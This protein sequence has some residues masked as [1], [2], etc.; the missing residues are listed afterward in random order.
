VV[1]ASGNLCGLRRVIP[2]RVKFTSELYNRAGSQRLRPHSLRPH[3]SE[4]ERERDR[5][6]QTEG[7]RGRHSERAR[8]RD[9]Q[10]G[11]ERQRQREGETQK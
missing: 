11:G 9:R 10:R 4:S 8:D 1:S 2:F 7:G 3:W 5:R 6:R